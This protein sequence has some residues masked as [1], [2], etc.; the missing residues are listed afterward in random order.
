MSFCTADMEW[1]PTSRILLTK[2]HNATHQFRW[3]WLNSMKPRKQDNFSCPMNQAC[4]HTNIT[5]EGLNLTFWTGS[6]RTRKVMQGYSN[7]TINFTS[8][9][10]ISCC[11]TFLQ[12]HGLPQD[13]RKTLRTAISQCNNTEMSVFVNQT[14]YILC[15]NS[16]PISNRTDWADYIHVIIQNEPTYT[17]P[18]LIRIPH[19]C[20][21]VSLLAQTYHIF[22]NITFPKLEPCMQKK[23]A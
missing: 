2:M 7:V 3:G 4:Y 1:T 19:T 15:H 9:V 22:L 10:N 20:I 17:T 12:V 14:T 11:Q 13:Y 21:N 23:R 5:A 8:E 6:G 18:Q 16:T